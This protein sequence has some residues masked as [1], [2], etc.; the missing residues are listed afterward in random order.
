MQGAKTS[1]PTI[2]WW[3]WSH[4]SFLR[5]IEGT[6]SSPCASRRNPQTLIQRS[7][8]TEPAFAHSGRVR[9]RVTTVDLWKLVRLIESR[10][11]PIGR[12]PAAKIPD[13]QACP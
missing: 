5:K 12:G 4:A 10:S 11:R 7:G 2:P 1:A 6:Y 13:P 3:A 8:D 9:G